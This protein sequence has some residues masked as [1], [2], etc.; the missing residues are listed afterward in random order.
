LKIYL[1]FQK[2]YWEIGNLEAYFTH[3]NK[4][5]ENLLGYTE[6]E[7]NITNRYRCKDG[8]YRY[9]EWIVRVDADKGIF[10]PLDGTYRKKYL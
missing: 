6:E 7:L 8:T 3:I 9:I 10:M 2:I 4:A 1:I 5:F